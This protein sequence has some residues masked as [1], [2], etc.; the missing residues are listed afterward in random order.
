M[1]KRTKMAKTDDSKDV[2][3]ALKY[4]SST[5]KDTPL[6]I[7]SVPFEEACAYLMPYGKYKDTPLGEMVADDS[8][9]RYLEM[10]LKWDDIRP[11]TAGN[12]ASV[13]KGYRIARKVYT[14]KSLKRKELE[15][16]VTEPEDNLEETPPKSQSK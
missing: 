15:D 10:Q 9:R 2:A 12:I 7:P 4:F 8:Q 6:E 13:L 5:F 3:A 1:A 14:E 16:A 11:K